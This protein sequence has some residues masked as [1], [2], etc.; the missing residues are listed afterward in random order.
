MHHNFISHLNA[1]PKTQAGLK[2]VSFVPRGETFSPPSLFA[3]QTLLWLSSPRISAPTRRRHNVPFLS[4]R[5][6]RKERQPSALW[7]GKSWLPFFLHISDDRS[8]FSCCGCLIAR[9]I[10][11]G[12]QRLVPWLLSIPCIPLPTPVASIV[13]T[14]GPFVCLKLK[15]LAWFDSGPPGAKK[16]C[17]WQISVSHTSLQISVKQIFR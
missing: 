16:M 2:L 3:S 1:V 6:C 7:I 4:A 17:V 15:S 12:C 13:S 10:P 5:C 8:L 11:Q 14:W 9:K